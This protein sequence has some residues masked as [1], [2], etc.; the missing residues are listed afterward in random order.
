[1]ADTQVDGR[2]T[3][4][5]PVRALFCNVMNARK[6]KRNGKEVG[7]AKFD[8]TFVLTAE[9]I[10]ALKD[11]AIEVAKAKWPGRDLK[12]LKFPFKKAE[13]VAEKQKAKGKDESIYTAG[14][15]LMSARSKYEPV[16]SYLDGKKVVEFTEANRGLAK[17]KFY[18][19]CFVVP[20]VNFVP[21][22]GDEDDGVNAYLDQVLWIKDGP[23][24]GG[25]SAAEAF[26]GYVGSVSAE[27]PTGGGEGN[28]VDDEIE[29]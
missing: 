18:N 2:V 12:E 1:M 16:L 21:Y 15:F 7:E 10:G 29:F 6:F 27:D 14:T 9:D 26:K 25:V 22:T 4:T 20:Q 5:R 13:K 19:G 24:I 23:K 8:A 11:K 28:G 3:L 17:Q